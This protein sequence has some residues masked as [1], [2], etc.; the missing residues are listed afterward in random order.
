TLASERRLRDAAAPLVDSF[1]KPAAHEH[2]SFALTF[3]S[4]DVPGTALREVDHCYAPLGNPLIAF[5]LVAGAGGARLHLDYDAACLSDEAMACLKD[6][7]QSVLGGCDAS[8]Q[9]GAPVR[10]ARLDIAAQAGFA[11]VVAGFAAAVQRGG[12][13]VFESA[14]GA[15]LGPAAL[16]HESN[17]FA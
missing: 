12:S 4:I 16:D 14:G 1:F 10:G 13:D 15:R 6:R 3:Q 11:N 9:G 17:A 2:E 5:T 8:T 7:L